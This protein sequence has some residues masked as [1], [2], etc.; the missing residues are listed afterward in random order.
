MNKESR[1]DLIFKN[2]SGNM[3]KIN[4]SPLVVTLN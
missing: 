4:V 2:Q 3:N 1:V